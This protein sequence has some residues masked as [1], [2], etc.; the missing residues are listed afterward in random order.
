V[1]REALPGGPPAALTE[2][3][4]DWVVFAC[5]DPAGAEHDSVA[6]AACTGLPP[7]L[8]ERVDL[9]LVGP[10]RPEYLRDLAP[11]T[12]VVI[13]DTVPGSGEV[14]ELPF[15]ELSGLEQPL[16]TSS[17]T[18]Q[19]LDEVVSMAQLLRSEPVSGTFVGLGVA[20]VELSRPPDPAAVERLRAAVAHVLAGMV[21]ASAGRA[22]TP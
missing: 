15:I 3:R 1:G 14:V 21:Q 13:V 17:A 16:V 19:P 20:S 8:L 12:H 5:G 22:T 9:K 10:M 11:G 2:Q 4:A 18:V 6:I 7:Q